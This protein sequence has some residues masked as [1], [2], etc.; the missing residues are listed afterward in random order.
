MRLD[1]ENQHDISIF[2]DKG[3]IH[4]STKEEDIVYL[5]QINEETNELVEK[6]MHVP[7]SAYLTEWEDFAKMLKGEV[8]LNF[9]D[10]MTGVMN[11]QVIETIIESSREPGKRITSL[12]S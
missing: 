9:P 12:R 4:A 3:T 2:G 5:I 6:K 8:R 7:K 10:F 11:Q 1:Q